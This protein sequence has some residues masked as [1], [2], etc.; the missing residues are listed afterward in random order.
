MSEDHV[1][2]GE[3]ADAESVPLNITH[4]YVK[5]LS[6]ENPGSPGLF[7]QPPDSAPDVAIEVNVAAQRLGDRAF[8]VILHVEARASADDTVL[9]ITELDY[10]AI[11]EV[12]AIPEEHLQPLILIEVP[13]LL[14]PF[15]RAIIS[16]VTRD[17]GFPPLMIS[18]VD[19]VEMFRRGA[20]AESE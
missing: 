20:E 5:D 9:F 18:T 3:S 12:G 2:A 15:A 10:A 19:F 1:A 11:V 13:R 14:F 8:E 17:G 7:L 16:N 4:Q 6:F